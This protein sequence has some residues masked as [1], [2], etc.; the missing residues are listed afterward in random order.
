MAQ[1]ATSMATIAASN[2][3]ILSGTTT[4]EN[5]LDLTGRFMAAF[6]R[7]DLDGVMAFFA[8]DAIYDEFN[9][10]RNASLAAIRAAFEPQFAGAFG[11]I[12]F[13]EEDLFVDAESGK[14]MASWRCTLEIKGDPTSW[15]GLALLHFV[16]GKLVRKLTY[17]KTKLPLFESA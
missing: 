13:L 14:V 1:E 11:P 7:L 9:G 17:A 8:E 10:R 15:R 5:L 3:R 4:R 2:Q 16:G 12:Q 6:N